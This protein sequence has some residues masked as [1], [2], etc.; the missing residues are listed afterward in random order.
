MTSGEGEFYNYD[1]VTPAKAGTWI[2][3]RP[4]DVHGIRN[5]GTKPLEIMWFWW[6]ENHAMPNW[7]CGGLPVL[8]KE[9]WQSKENKPDPKPSRQPKDL[10]NDDRF[11]YLP[12]R[13]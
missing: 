12:K 2:L 5:T 11:I 8:P 3:I 4:F 9:C 1:R 6:N 13:G 10:E 7:D